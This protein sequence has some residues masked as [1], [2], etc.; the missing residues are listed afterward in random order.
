M[1][2]TYYNSLNFADVEDLADFYHSGL[3]EMQSI[4]SVIENCKSLFRL[5]ADRV[6]LQVSEGDRV[7]KV[8]MLSPELN[9]YPIGWFVLV[10]L[11]KQVD[12]YSSDDPYMPIAQWDNKKIA[13]KNFSALFDRAGVEK[14]FSQVVNAS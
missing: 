11:N 14:A 13:F 1:L 2:T 10:P 6:I 3:P 7:Y 9:R 4:K 5:P 12:L 8:L